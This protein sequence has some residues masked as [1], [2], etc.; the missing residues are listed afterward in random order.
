MLAI[1]VA[2]GYFDRHDVCYQV[3]SGGDTDTK[4]TRP[5]GNG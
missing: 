2:F 4:S 3:I 5:Q 1:V